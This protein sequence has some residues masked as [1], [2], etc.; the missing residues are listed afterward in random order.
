[1]SAPRASLNP[2]LQRLGIGAE[3]EPHSAEL[4]IN[5]ANGLRRR[6]DRQSE[7]VFNQLMVEQGFFRPPSNS[8]LRRRARWPTLARL[9]GHAILFA[10]HH[11]AGRRLEHVAPRNGAFVPL[12]ER[13]RKRGFIGRWPTG[14]TF[15]T[16]ICRS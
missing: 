3:E 2:A 6:A 16:A 11:R 1:L 10:Y 7:Q 13:R 14:V 12:T 8:R 15:Q 5:L 4:L 9:I